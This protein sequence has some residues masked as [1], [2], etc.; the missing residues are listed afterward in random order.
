[1]FVR[2]KILWTLIGISSLIVCAL[3]IVFAQSPVVKTS[4]APN[5]IQEKTIRNGETQKYPFNLKTGQFINAEV[6]FRGNNLLVSIFA[7]DGTLLTQIKS[8]SGILWR[9]GAA[10]VAAVDGTYTIEVKFD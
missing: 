8:Q 9:M 6:E 5:Q 3:P 10:A 1:M 2:C 7:P 4:P